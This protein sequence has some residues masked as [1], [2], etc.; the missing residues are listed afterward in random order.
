MSVLRV[1]GSNQQWAQ[2]DLDGDGVA[3]GYVFK[4]F[5]KPS[6]PVA[7]PRSLATQPEAEVGDE[8]CAADCEAIEE[9]P[10]DFHPCGLRAPVA[11]VTD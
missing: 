6:Q 1:D 8:G 11:E 4:T 5:L 10:S 3:D 7:A 2:I 9:P